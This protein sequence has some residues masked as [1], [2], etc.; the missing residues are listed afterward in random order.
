MSYRR[1]RPAATLP[2]ALA[3]TALAALS[4]A[5]TSVHAAPQNGKS[6]PVSAKIPFS[7]P[8][9]KALD[10]VLLDAIKNAPPATQYPNSS[11]ARLLD[12]GTVAVK[13]DGTTV[14]EYRVTYKLYKNN[15]ISQRLAEVVLPYNASYQDLRVLSA[16]TIKKDGTVLDVKREDMRDGGIAGDYLMYDDA[17]GINFSMPGIEDECV[18]DYTFQMITHPMFLPGQFTTYWG[19]SGF[20]PVGVSRLTLKTPADKPMKFKMYNDKLEPVVTTSVDGHTKTYVWEKKNLAPLEF[21][22]S[23]PKADD[24]K[25]WMEAS[26]LDG[27][28]DIAGWFWGLQQPQA[29]S[30]DAIRKTVASVTAG[31]TTDADKCRAIYDWVANRTRYVGIEFGI[32]AYKPHPASDVHDKMYGDCKDKANLLITMLNLANIKA[33]PVLL[34]AG[35]RRMVGDGLPTL[36]A[37]NHCIAVADVDGKEVWLDATAETCA[38]GDIPDGDRGVQALVVRDGKGKFETIPMYNP[39]E[40]SMDVKTTIKMLADGSAQTQSQANMSGEFGQSMRYSVRLI[41]PDKRKDVMQSMA[42]KLG[43]S[44]K[45]KEFGLPDGQDKTGPFTMNMTLDSA[46]YGKPTGKSLLILPLVSSING[47]KEN[48]Y[49]AEKRIWPIVEEDTSSIR[50]ETVLTIPDGFEIDDLPGNVDLTC[51]IQEYHRAIT[52]SAD[53]KTVTITDSFVSKPG[54]VPAADYAKVRGFYDE[55]LKASDDQIVLKKSGH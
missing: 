17:H 12:L 29:K 7:G 18:I 32:S 33:H 51:P 13:S 44:G 20:E 25:I 1:R 42:G 46:H 50:S 36:N 19:F 28:Q 48:P 23:M 31:K 2:S 30:T 37:F 5:A 3:L 34:H 49:K 22:P 26:S 15:A 6:K 39:T 16:R 27:W 52:K 8:A 40:N 24:V 54:T 41:T 9:K 45:V 10:P 55:M 35:E 53:G 38:Y 43:L 11:Y 14:A 47:F 21:E 4:L